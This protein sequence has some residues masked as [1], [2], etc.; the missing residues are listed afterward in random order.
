MSK[1]FFICFL[2]L[3]IVRNNYYLTGKIIIPDR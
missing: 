3:K 2:F 1:S